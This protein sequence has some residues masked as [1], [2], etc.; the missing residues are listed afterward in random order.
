MN[1]QTGNNT[2]ERSPVIVIMG[3]IDHGKST[4]LDH[5]RKTNI[6]DK[7]AGGITQKISAYEVK[8]EGKDG[9]IHRITFLD[10]PGH[11]AFQTMRIRG[12][13]V[14]DIA[15][16]VVS[17]EDGVKPQTLEAL[18]SILKA[19]IP[20]IVAINKVDKPG[21]DIERTKQSLAENEIYVEGYGGSI[22]WVAISAKTGQGVPELLD[23]MLLVAEMEELQGNP[24]TSASG[25]I[26]EANTDPKKGVA[27]TLIIKE[28]TL[29]TGMT[30]VAE[31]SM[32]PTRIMEDFMGRKIKEATFSSPIQIIGWN[33]MPKVGAKFISFDS[34][35]EAEAY[36][37]EKRSSQKKSPSKDTIQETNE[38]SVTIP[39]ILKTDAQGT[40][41][42]IEHELKKLTTEKVI[43]KIIH[44]GTGTIT[45]A[46]VKSAGSNTKT[47]IIGFNVKVDSQAKDVAE[48]M[49]LEV[50]TFDIIYKLGEW[51][52]EVCKER[53]PKK[54]VEE[55]TGRA[56]V[57][58]T[59]S[60]TKDKQV[61]GGRVEMGTFT[62]GMD[63]RIIR[64]EAMIGMGKIKELQQQKNKTGKVEEG[65]EFGC[66][67]QSP[68]ETAPGD[69]LEL[70]S[71]I[72]K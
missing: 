15:V 17:A 7:E 6:V 10:T 13:D 57:L 3:H 24:K 20:Y 39:I 58:K 44:S 69:K 21:A 36:M 23:M 30:V 33:F 42:A 12:A 60:R 45:E 2:V 4:L 5:I 46:D 28:G 16:L 48:R 27:A 62:V 22:P 72:E 67:I 70:I 8:H 29:K 43:P 37:E 31:E 71:L 64:R 66:L 34:K 40:I 1:K 63:V 54:F 61:I 68:I 50:K 52:A 38:E 65:S 55:V 53:T 32:A 9:K 49:L 51:L 11:E 14:A 25:V 19:E 59:F 41:E 35:K 47:L 18:K 56:K 26:V